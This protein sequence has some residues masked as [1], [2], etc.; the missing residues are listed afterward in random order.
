MRALF[1]IL[2]L[3]TLATPGLANAQMTSGGGV[4]Q[5][6][7]GTVKPGMADSLRS[8]VNERVDD[9]DRNSRVD[10][11]R[12][13]GRPNA[14]AVLADAQ[15]AVGA[16]GLE[17]R[18]VEATAM[19]Q[20]DAGAVYEVACADAP[21]RLVL[22]SS[23]PQAFNCLALAASAANGGDASTQCDMAA[24]KDAIAAMKGYARALSISC[25]I[26]QAAWIGRLASGA[27]RYEVGCPGAAGFWIEASPAGAPLTKTPCAE[28]VL[29]HAACRFTTPDEL[30]AGG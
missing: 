6:V 20:S 3:F 15:A 17:C 13:R 21:G 28:V 27:D 29:A 2:A 4:N 7:P 11:R 8:T 19:G 16:A 9:A 10:E 1:P 30:A 12:R 26:D 5:P 24:N 22:T 14:A 18:A 25:A 23:P